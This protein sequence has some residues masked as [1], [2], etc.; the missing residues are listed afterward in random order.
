MT[1]KVR[2]LNDHVMRLGWV[3]SYK[4]YQK[5]H[6]EYMLYWWK[7]PDGR[8]LAL[9]WLQNAT[10]C[11]YQCHAICLS[12]HLSV[13]THGV[14]LQGGDLPGPTIGHLHRSQTPLSSPLLLH[15]LLEH[16]SQPGRQE[17]KKG[18]ESGNQC[19]RQWWVPG[20]VNSGWGE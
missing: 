4:Y 14:G 7:F 2:S 20:R 17:M 18:W 19:T 9:L 10:S 6:N 3:L 8:G 12:L 11:L 15:L 13:S 1:N 16:L 5:V